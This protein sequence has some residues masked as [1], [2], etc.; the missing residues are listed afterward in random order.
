MFGTQSMQKKI[1]YVLNG[2]ITVL[3]RL[4]EYYLIT[5]DKKAENYIL[6][7]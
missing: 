7:A 3:I 5:T 4:R 1:P 2:F 6:K